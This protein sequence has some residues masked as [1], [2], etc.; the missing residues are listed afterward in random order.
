M[1]IGT[2]ALIGGLSMPVGAAVVPDEVAVCVQPE[3]LFDVFSTTETCVAAPPETVSA[4]LKAAQERWDDLVGLLGRRTV[5]AWFGPRP[6][7][8]DVWSPPIT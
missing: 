2:V 7:L 1:L 6:T 8:A 5:I 3:T 4:A